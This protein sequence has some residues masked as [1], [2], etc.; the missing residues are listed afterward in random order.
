[1][2]RNSQPFL[3]LFTLPYWQK[4]VDLCHTADKVAFT[5]VTNDPAKL[6]QA[7]DAYSNSPNKF[8][9]KQL[10]IVDVLSAVS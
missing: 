8:S 2:C 3:K 1:M 6:H 5:I 10:F 9:F 7:L 4:R